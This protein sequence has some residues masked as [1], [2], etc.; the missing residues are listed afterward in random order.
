MSFRDS[1]PSYL[2]FGWF[3]GYEVLKKLFRK[4]KFPHLKKAPEKIMKHGH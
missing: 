3:V 4:Q 1:S 2:T